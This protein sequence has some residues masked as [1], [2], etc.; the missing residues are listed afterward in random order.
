MS[1][2][3]R[4]LQKG[5]M[6]M[7]EKEKEIIEIPQSQEQAFED[8]V[9]E[10]EWESDWGAVFWCCFFLAIA[11]CGMGIAAWQPWVI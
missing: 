3:Q 4:T 10:E 5:T 11:L 7:S 2:K 8:G 1:A 9:A 6:N